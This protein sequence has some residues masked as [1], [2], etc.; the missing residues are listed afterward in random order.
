MVGH[1]QPVGQAKG[2]R[3]K[4]AIVFAALVALCVTVVA[5]LAEPLFALLLLLAA[6][7]GALWV[8]AGN[9]VANDDEA[10]DVD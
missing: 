10:R 3:V 7:L 6:I 4:R 1:G 8:V 2:G 5:A 9:I